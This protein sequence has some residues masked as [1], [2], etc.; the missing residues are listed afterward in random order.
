[1]LGAGL[2]HGSYGGALPSAYPPTPPPDPTPADPGRR[3]PQ[4][5]GLVQAKVMLAPFA[6]LAVLLGD[7]LPE[8]SQLLHAR[9]EGLP[10]GTS[11]SSRVHGPNHVVLHQAALSVVIAGVYREEAKKS[12]RS[13]FQ[14]DG[15]SRDGPSGPLMVT[16]TTNIHAIVPSDWCG[17]SISGFTA[18]L[19]GR[20]EHPSFNAWAAR[21]AL[22]P[23][24]DAGGGG[25]GGREDEHR[26]SGPSPG[27]GVQ[28]LLGSV[29][30][31]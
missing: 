21:S 4:L 15:P 17:F 31:P 6:Q 12:F 22:L 8:H 2:G 29:S 5:L 20:C 24:W 9:R 18:T 10:G 25:G 16:G 11:S 28:S 13:S 23:A 7:L 3:W 27:G 26:P 1:M 30:L 14:R 19:G